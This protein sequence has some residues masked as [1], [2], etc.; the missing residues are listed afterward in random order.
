MNKKLKQLVYKFFD[1][2]ISSTEEKVLQ[3]GFK[4]S[5]ALQKEFQKLKNMRAH[6]NDM[7]YNFSPAFASKV[8]QK[9][10]ESKDDINESISKI[11]PS[12][13]YA[14]VAAI[15]ILLITS[16]F[17]SDTFSVQ[18]ILGIDIF[19]DD[20]LSFLLYDF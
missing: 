4:E 11:F 13:F 5:D 16:V 20:H 9:I 17:V 2:E 6:F 3:E 10:K 7:D 15:I 8:M 1:A 12:F 14:A 19:Y 18:S